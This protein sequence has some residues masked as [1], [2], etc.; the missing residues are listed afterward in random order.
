[1]SDNQIPLAHLRVCVCV[2]GLKRAVPIE[3]R[4][5]IAL[6]MPLRMP[7]AALL[8]V[9]RESIMPTRTKSLAYFLAFLA[10]Y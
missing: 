7:T 10:S 5:A 3:Q 1:M 6:D 9:A 2:S 8:N 4:Q